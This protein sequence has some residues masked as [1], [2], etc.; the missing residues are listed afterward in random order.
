MKR[1]AF[2]IAILVISLALMPVSVFADQTSGKVKVGFSGVDQDDVKEGVAEYNYLENGVDPTIDLDIDGWQKGIKYDVDFNIKTDDEMGGSL[3][4]DVKRYFRTQNKFQRFTHWLENDDLINYQVDPDY[5]FDFSHGPVYTAM[6]NRGIFAQPD[7]LGANVAV[8][9][10]N[11]W[12]KDMY[13]HHELYTSDNEFL[14][15][16]AEFV[17]I[18][19]GYRREI[20]RGYEQSRATSKCMGCHLGADDRRVDEKTEDFKIG[21]TASLGLLTV[22]YTFLH[23][24]FDDRASSPQHEYD[25]VA[26]SLA[27]KVAFSEAD[28]YINYDATPESEKDSHVVKAKLDLPL[29][30][31]FFATYV[32]STVENNDAT[33]NNQQVSISDDPEYDYDRVAAR[34]T[35]APIRN[36]VLSFRY[37]HE[38]IDNDDV[39]INYADA[40]DPI[41]GSG[42]TLTAPPEDYGLHGYDQAHD[43]YPRTRESSLS[44]DVDTYGAKLKYRLFKRTSVLLGY[45]REEIDRDDYEV[46][47]T[48]TDTFTVALNSRYLKNLSLRLKYRYADIDDPF[49]HLDAGVADASAMS[50]WLKA[51]ATC[52]AAPP[53]CTTA[54]LPGPGSPAS[55]EYY[56]MYNS[57]EADFTSE[58]EDEHEFTANL[59]Y[60]FSPKLSANFHYKYL[61]QEVSEDVP[62]F[63]G[64]FDKEMHAPGIDLWFAPTDQ[65]VLT[66]AYQ[67][68][69]MEDETFFS[70]PAFGG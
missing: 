50:D 22:D 48:D 67:Y 32:N 38:N 45:E 47:S 8:E 15:P 57:R 21:A 18:H 61:L 28:G 13:I 27:H 6:G 52:T 4:F 65:L 62:V 42:N 19:A 30:T 24:E 31:S 64:N 39:T 66:L 70:L 40:Y 33:D 25:M 54:H 68:Q 44:R 46:D 26:G 56:V 7:F 58:P 5:V 2:A 23:R 53:A 69:K 14:I 20:R 43:G 37:A 11:S 36:L 41:H 16:G 10:N 59:T 34:L 12:G 63:S 9:R 3:N 60:S 1:I 49:A 55:T 29:N 51:N 17:K 35:T